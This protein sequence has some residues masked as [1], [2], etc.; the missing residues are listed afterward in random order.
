MSETDP[1]SLSFSTR[2]ERAFG[3]PGP[4]G[5]AS[6]DPETTFLRGVVERLR[7]SVS[8]AD[9]DEPSP[10]ALRGVLA[11][12]RDRSTADAPSWLERIVASLVH[13]SR[14]GAPAGWRSSATDGVVHC[15]Y[16]CSL[17]RLD[18]QAVAAEEG[19]LW[20]LRGA[21][22]ADEREATRATLRRIDVDGL[23]IL[24]DVVDGAFAADV[25]PG[26]Y[27]IEIE[28]DDGRAAFVADIDLSTV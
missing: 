18:L 8:T 4:S 21:V 20:R 28:L 7:E 22:L 27:E 16:E 24:V 25:E 14:S 15:A 6:S 19:R 2:V 13:D 5:L 10:A 3:D 1:E 23:P 11:A 17:G 26:R 12:F 9:L